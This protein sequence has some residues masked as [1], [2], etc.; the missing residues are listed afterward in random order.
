[1]RLSGSTLLAGAGLAL[2][3]AAIAGA[4]AYP[5]VP[6]PPASVGKGG[7]CTTMPGTYPQADCDDTPEDCKQL[8]TTCP[9]TPCD[10]TSPCLAMAQN[11]ADKPADLRI[12][13]LNITA[14]PS[15]VS[16]P[17]LQHSIID[18]GVNLKNLCGEGGDGS[19]SWLIHFDTIT[20][21]ET[22]GGAPPT[23]DPFNVGYCFVNEQINGMQVKPV[24][25]GVT[26]NADGTWTSDLIPKLY[27]P[28]YVHG[29]ASNMVILP[30][31]DAKVQ[32]VTHSAAGN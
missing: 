12:R 22:T 29:Q 15:L 2:C 26:K 17:F 13:K 23:D 4:C 14:P 10:G 8:S 31:T 27:V 5:S 20:K 11:S 32:E 16:P 3:A 1:M 6:P 9:T 28:I 7:T 24:T 25:V 21:Q 18:Q 30:L 19:F